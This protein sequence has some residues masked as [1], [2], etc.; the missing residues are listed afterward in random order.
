MGGT[1]CSI[2]VAWAQLDACRRGKKKLGF[3]PD[4][5]EG[6]HNRSWGERRK[7]CSKRKKKIRGPVVY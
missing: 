1:E 7:A 6:I 2:V 5:N 3:V 4:K